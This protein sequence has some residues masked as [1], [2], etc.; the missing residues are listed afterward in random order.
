MLVQFKYR[1]TASRLSGKQT[2]RNPFKPFWV[3]GIV[4]VMHL[5]N[6]VVEDITRHQGHCTTAPSCSCE[7]G[8]NGSSFSKKKIQKNRTPIYQNK[9][10]L[11]MRNSRETESIPALLYQLV[12]FFTAAFVHLTATFMALI[13]KTT[14]DLLTRH[15]SWLSHESRRLDWPY[16][17]STNQS[18][19]KPITQIFK[20]LEN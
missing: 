3:S 5:F 2:L 4:S 17:R 20:I 9:I 1:S 18:H 16:S 10:N 6:E 7:P 12:K 11:L 14:Q 8:A 13:H 19:D 15:K